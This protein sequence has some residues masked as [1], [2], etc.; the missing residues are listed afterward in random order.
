MREH[1]DDYE[2]QAPVTKIDGRENSTLEELASPG[3]QFSIFS[4][5]QK[6]A[7]AVAGSCAAF[8]SPA[9]SN[10]YFPALVTIARDVHVSLSQIN[11]TITT[12]QIVQGIA[13][14]LVAGFSDSAGRRP[15]Y[16]ICFVVYTAA[17]LG[18]ALQSSFASLL[19]LRLLQSA[20]SSGMVALAIALVGDVCVSSERGT[21]IAWATAMDLIGPAVAPIAGGLISQRLN[22][23]WIF[24]ILLMVSVPFFLL[25]VMFMPETCRSVVG[26]GSIPPP[27]FNMSIYDFL[28]RNPR[29]LQG[30]DARQQQLQ[31]ES[32]NQ[33]T[34]IS[35]LWSTL[36]IAFNLNSFLLLL[37]NAFARATFY[38]ITTDASA[39]FHTTYGFNDICVSL[40]FIPI[41]VGGI[42]SSLVMGQIIDWNY[43]RYMKR[44]SAPHGSSGDE[45]SE[46]RHIPLEKARLELGIP[47]YLAATCLIIAYGWCLESHVSIAGPIVILFATSFVLTASTQVL[48]SLMIDLWPGRSGAAAA[49]N[50]LFRCTLGAGASAVIEPMSNAIGRGW[51]F[52]TLALISASSVPLLGIIVRRGNAHTGPDRVR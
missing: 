45:W 1:T 6:R 31:T 23:H 24:W 12:Y 21:Y 11:L 20:G 26:N 30:L 22:W 13:P 43:K 5:T 37:T 48:S 29:S 16:L 7:I 49:A 41:G 8:F 2:E 40:M 51:A 19:G 27:I 47:L 15:A 42:A 34:V 18:L 28:R 50:N 46:S 33:K 38:S 32:G 39:A 36:K 25:M 35:S 4:S 10:I 44:L 52:T 14:M 9:S 17:N 3:E